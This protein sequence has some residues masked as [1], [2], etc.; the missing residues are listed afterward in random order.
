MVTVYMV[1]HKIGLA[2]PPRYHMVYYR[3]ICAKR[4]VVRRL[5]FIQHCTDESL[6]LTS[7]PNHNFYSFS[8]YIMFMLCHIYWIC[9]IGISY[10]LHEDGDEGVEALANAMKEFLQVHCTSFIALSLSLYI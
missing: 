2:P 4:M 3:C 5:W 1:I 8:L 7:N 10:E 9:L 6:E